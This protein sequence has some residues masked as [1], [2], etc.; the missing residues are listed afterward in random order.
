MATLKLTTNCTLNENGSVA[1]SATITD[2]NGIPQALF[3]HKVGKTPNLDGYAGVATPWEIV[4]Y[5]SVRDAARAYYRLGTATLPALDL[6]T[7]SVIKTSLR[8]FLTETINAY[9]T[10]AEIEGVEETVIESEE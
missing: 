9:A 4:T 2:A 6:A 8:D 1:I 10:F 5:P 3:L 7:A